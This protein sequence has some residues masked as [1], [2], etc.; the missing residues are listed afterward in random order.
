VNNTAAFTEQRMLE[1]RQHASEARL[2][3]LGRAERH[4]RPSLL[5][6]LRGRSR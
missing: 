5:A 1:A 4:P 2:A 3:R 6:R